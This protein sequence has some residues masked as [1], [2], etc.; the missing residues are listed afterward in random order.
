MEAHNVR[1]I[2]G[3]PQL[4]KKKTLR[5]RTSVIVPVQPDREGDA[6][7]AQ[8]NEEPLRQSEQRFRAA[9]DAVEGVLWTNNAAGEMEGE[10]PAWA[11]LTG[12]TYEEDRKSIRDLFQ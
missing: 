9:V 2:L 4:M 1:R 12:Q 10:Q 3:A 6:I 5:L 7:T 11:A 8:R